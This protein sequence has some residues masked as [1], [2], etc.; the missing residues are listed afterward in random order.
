MRG[1]LSKLQ[2]M[3]LQELSSRNLER[4]SSFGVPLVMP[5][6]HVIGSAVVGQISCSSSSST[7]SAASNATTNTTNSARLVEQKIRKTGRS[8]GSSAN[9]PVFRA[10]NRSEDSILSPK[11]VSKPEIQ[12][13]SALEYESLPDGACFNRSVVSQDHNN[14]LERLGGGGVSR[15]CHNSSQLTSKRNRNHINNNINNNNNNNNHHHHRFSTATLDSNMR[16]TRNAQYLGCF[17]VQAASQNGRADFV[18]KQLLQMKDSTEHANVSITISLAGVQVA[19][20]D[21]E[22]SK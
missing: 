2:I 8:Q 11:G 4:F 10:R 14:G 22:V 1:D 12:V 17:Q 15:E 5:Q 6:K 21:E 19:H 18:R 9:K 13:I 20:Q 3:E 16:V 7:S